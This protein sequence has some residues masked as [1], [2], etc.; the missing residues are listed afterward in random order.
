MQVTTCLYLN[1]NYTE[2]SLNIIEI[3]A[4]LFSKKGF[5][6]VTTQEIALASKVNEVT[7]FRHFKSKDNLFEEVVKYISSKPD[8]DKFIKQDEKELVNYLYGIGDLLHTF[9]IDNFDLLKIELMD[10]QKF[11]EIEHIS[12]FL[13]HVQKLFVQY[14]VKKQDFNKS[15]ADDYTICF[16]TAVHGLCMNIYLLDTFNSK[17]DFNSLLKYLI[18]SFK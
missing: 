10:R 2:K 13:N 12:K 6:A 9:F 5:K 14:L 4:K 8:I 7:I 3:A 18:N 15:D 16:M 17:P 11:N 1:M